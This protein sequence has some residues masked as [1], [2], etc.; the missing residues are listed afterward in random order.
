MHL[1]PVS[2]RGFYKPPGNAV[3][4]TP[5]RGLI[6]SVPFTGPDFCNLAPST[7]V[8]GASAPGISEVWPSNRGSAIKSSFGPHGYGAVFSGATG[9]T[10]CLGYR[11]RKTGVFSIE[12]LFRT[13]SSITTVQIGSYNGNANGGN[14]SNDGNIG[15]DSSGRMYFDVYDA[16]AAGH[17]TA[18]DTSTTY[19]ANTVYH[20]VGVAD[21]TNIRLYLNG[22]QVASTAAGSTDI[23]YSVGSFFCLGASSVLGGTPV[24]SDVTLFLAN[25]ATLPWTPAEVLARAQDPFSPFTFVD[26]DLTALLVGRQAVSGRLFRNSLLNGLGSGGRFFNNPVG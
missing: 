2:F 18:T 26:D 3:I 21:G 13:G 11:C 12:F 24:Q 7:A 10:N 4:S 23:S 5:P 17:K 16:G 8:A 9:S 25:V 1:S 22:R 14:G 6:L 15:F 19:A 20:A